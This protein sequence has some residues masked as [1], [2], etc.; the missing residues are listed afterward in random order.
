MEEKWSPL[1]EMRLLV[2]TKYDTI[3]YNI[4]LTKFSLNYLLLG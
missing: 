3:I 4:K 2:F 1:R